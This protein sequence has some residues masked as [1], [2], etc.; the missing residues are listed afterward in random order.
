MII[1]CSSCV[2]LNFGKCTFRHISVINW[3]DLA[4]LVCKILNAQDIAH[5]KKKK[6]KK[7]LY[8][9]LGSMM[10]NPL[11]FSVGGGAMGVVISESKLI[12]A[13][14]DNCFQ[15]AQQES[16]HWVSQ[17]LYNHPDI[18]GI[19]TLK[20]SKVWDINSQLMGIY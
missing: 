12:T 15:N 14:T 1:K 3:H 18:S 6:E 2:R 16:F 5:K 13:S 4:I 10:I 8:M 20:R 19:L 7:F 9:Q 17:T 11:T